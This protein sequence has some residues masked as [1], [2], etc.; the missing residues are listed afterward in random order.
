ML[1]FQDGRRVPN[2]G[3]Y[4][5]TIIVQIP[6]TVIDEVLGGWSPFSTLFSLAILLPSLAVT[7]RR[8]HDTDRTCW[9]LLAMAGVFALIGLMAVLG[10]GGPYAGSM[11]ASFTGMIIAILVVLFGSITF[12]VFMILP[13]TEGPNRYGPDPYGPDS[14]EEVFA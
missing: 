10:R 1:S 12:L 13:G 3:F 4:L 11:A 5:A 8:L 14:L 6:L 2:I 7:V 9:W